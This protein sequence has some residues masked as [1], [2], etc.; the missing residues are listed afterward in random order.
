M[1]DNNRVDNID[2]ID[3][4]NT[5]DDTDSVDTGPQSVTVT[6][7]TTATVDELWD[8]WQYV[9]ALVAVAG[10]RMTAIG[11][12]WKD[13]TDPAVKAGVWSAYEA[14]AR[15]YRVLASWGQLFYAA[16]VFATDGADCAALNSSP[17]S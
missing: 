14:E 2:N 6:L 9:S 13:T 7:E 4:V 17:L 8:Q 1:P 5:V 16:Y 3:S 15:D 10:E 12:Q 11:Q